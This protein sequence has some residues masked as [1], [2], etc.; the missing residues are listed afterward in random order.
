LCGTRHGSGL[1]LIY[2]RA[3]E[4]TVLI[5]KM[6][7]VP[8]KDVEMQGAEMVKMRLLLSEEDGALNFRMRFFEVE[9]GGCSPYHSHNYEHE[10]LVLDGDGELR[11]KDQVHPLKVGDVVYV[12]PNEE[13]QLRN[14]GDDKF[15]FICLIPSV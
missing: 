13:H 5:K 7:E 12:S 14:V 15:R 8:A 9:Q 4:L 3:K 1:K 11:G 6:E 2:S 10:V